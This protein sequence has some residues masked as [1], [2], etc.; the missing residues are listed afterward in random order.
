MT[1]IE[2]KIIADKL[3][4]KIYNSVLKISTT[5]HACSQIKYVLNNDFKK[6]NKN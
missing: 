2:I 1:E 3:K 6:N 5:F 4:K